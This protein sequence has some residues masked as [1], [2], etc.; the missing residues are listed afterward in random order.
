[1][2]PKTLV[3]LET[4]HLLISPVL[5]TVQD[6]GILKKQCEE[7]HHVL[8]AVEYHLKS[9]MKPTASRLPTGLPISER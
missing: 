1:M 8:R 2:N 7:H 6:Q 5:L 3:N 4:Q 9:T